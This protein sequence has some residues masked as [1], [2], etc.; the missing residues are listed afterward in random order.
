MREF[1]EGIDFGGVP[2]DTQITMG[3]SAE[4]ICG[5]AEQEKMDLIVTST[6]GRTGFMHVLIGSV[7]EYIVRNAPSPVLVVPASV[8]ELQS[9]KAGC[10]IVKRC[11]FLLIALAASAP[12]QPSAS[13][14]ASEVPSHS[15]PIE[16]VLVPVPHEVFESLDKFPNANWAKVQ[17]RGLSRWKPHGEQAQT[18]LL[19]G[20]IIAEGFIAVQARDQ[21]Q[22]KRIGTAVLEISAALGVKHSV[23][24]RSKAIM[25]AADRSDWPAVREE[26]D[27]VSANVEGAM[28]ELDSEQLAQLVSLGGWLRGAEA[29]TTLILQNYSPDKAELLRQPVLLD[30]FEKRIAEM[31]PELQSDALVAKMRQGIP[32][33]RPLMAS[34]GQATISEETVKKIGAMTKE[35]VEEINRKKR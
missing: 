21:E 10:L 31:K 34:E 15:K 6:H 20:A 12:A 23:L 9:S 24:P 17:R 16:N 8:K 26:W 3:R 35:L 22:V 32:K 5:Y 29:L 2:F 7:A 18:A 13:P 28:R 30:H 11:L 25:E 27:A 14:P 33:I 1:A 19:L 4:E